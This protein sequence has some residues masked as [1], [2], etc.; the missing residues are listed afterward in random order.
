[1]FRA[2]LSSKP[3][4]TRVPFA[5][6]GTHVPFAKGTYVF[7]QDVAD[8]DNFA[9]VAA[10]IDRFGMPTKDRPVHFV[11][12]QRPEDLGMP[13]FHTG[14]AFRFPGVVPSKPERISKEDSQLVAV[15]G[16]AR[17]KAFLRLLGVPSDAVIIYDGGCS[18][19]SSNM[20]H[21]LHARDFL[22]VNPVN[23]DITTPEN[24]NRL[25]SELNGAVFV[26]PDTNM[27]SQEMEPD[28]FKNA[29]RERCRAFMTQQLDELAETT[30]TQMDFQPLEHLYDFLAGDDCKE[31]V[32]FALAP[33]TPLPKLFQMDDRR[34]QKG[35]RG[36]IREKLRRV[37]GQLF[38]WDNCAPHFWTRSPQAVNI[39]KNQ[40]NVD[41]DTEAVE[42][43]LSQLPE[44]N[45]LT[46][47]VLI[48]T[49]A[50]KDPDVLA[51]YESLDQ[52]LRVEPFDKL[53]PNARLWR[54][55]N[56]IKGDKTQPIFDPTV[57]FMWGQMEID[58]Y[59]STCANKLFEM[60]SARVIIPDNQS[61]YKW[62][63]RPVFR[64]MPGDS[65]GMNM[66]AALEV[67]KK[68]FE[69]FKKMM[70]ELLWLLPSSS[71]LPSTSLMAE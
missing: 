28:T 29:R 8:S 20:S 25:Q 23:G 3:I 51:F 59:D 58:G 70:R 66:C 36:V 63:D 49:E 16:A 17:L 45:G 22:F 68:E 41:C 67:N 34:I 11:L 9:S 60:T 46:E 43:V 56:A 33:L 12:V 30:G 55:W 13:K 40:F 69:N 47:I 53:P 18:E 15:H 65:D 26:D 37:F 5:P 4:G 35:K 57:I 32:I 44:C 52:E 39:L 48:P 6:I 31:F 38:A 71:D 24:Y 2:S 54:Q 50:I 19:Q 42:S 61:D 10:F 27:Y 14:C 1:M 62:K 7:L 21:H 64:L